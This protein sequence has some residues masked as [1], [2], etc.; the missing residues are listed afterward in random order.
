[1]LWMD[2][3]RPDGYGKFQAARRQYLAHRFAYELAYGPIPDGMVI[4]HVK[5]KGCTNKHC[6]APLHLEAVTQAENMRRGEVFTARPPL[7]IH[8]P[9][10]HPYSGD[11]VRLA[12]QGRRVCRACARE[13][14][15]RRRAQKC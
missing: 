6:V 8:C 9:K 15:A 14:A 10:G 13:Y 12:P 7:K 2:K 3:P 4:D 1:M 5:G 11:N